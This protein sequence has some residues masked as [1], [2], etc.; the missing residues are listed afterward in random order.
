MAVSRS[1]IYLRLSSNNQA[2]LYNNFLS[3]GKQYQACVSYAQNNNFIIKETIEEVISAYKIQRRELDDILDNNNNIHIIFYNISRFSR[4]CVKGLVYINKA[5]S[6][7]IVFHFVQENLRTDNI[8]FSHHIRT[9]LSLAQNESEIISNR[10]KSTCKLLKD[11]GHK[12]GKVPY[13]FTVS[14]NEIR[15]FIPLSNEYDVINFII[16]ARSDTT[17]SLELNNILKKLAPNNFIPIEIYEEKYG[18]IIP[19]N[20]YINP[21]RFKNISDI[22]NEY[23]VLK[24]GKKWTAQSVSYIFNKYMSLKINKINKTLDNLVIDI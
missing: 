21:L 11:K 13:G 7:K 2:K 1:I 9:G 19:P 18:S 12:F 15:Q 24:R 3:F 14:N 16:K 10:I 23:S 20:R 5:L 4:N 8:S 17:T 6:K 22:L